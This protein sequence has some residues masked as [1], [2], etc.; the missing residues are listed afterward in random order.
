MSFTFWLGTHKPCWL[1]RTDVPLFVSRRRLAE[2]KRLPR[3]VGPWA[4]DSGGF[5]ELTKYGEWRLGPRDYVDLVWRFCCEVG[6]PEWAA[7]QDW[8]CE[9]EIL[10]KTGGS[11][12]GHQ[13]LTVHNYLDLMDREPDIPWA[14]V[15]QG[16]RTPYDYR[17]HVE[18][19]DQCGVDLAALPVVGVGSVCRRGPDPG[20]EWLFM[21]LALK[22]GLR[23]LHAFGYKKSGLI[24]TPIIA[25]TDYMIS[26]DSM[27]WSTHARHRPS[28]PGCSHGVDG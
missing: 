3:A 23:N 11:V 13:L 14:P 20:T 21:D 6:I 1:E 4:L 5:T 2:Y 15:L 17:K 8:M 12:R 24:G 28:M 10:K 9:P 7:Q 25:P 19:F 16:W 26:S 22:D 18:M 27:A